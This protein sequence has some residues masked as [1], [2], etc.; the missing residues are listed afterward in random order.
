MTDIN[1]AK[2]DWKYKQVKGINLV[3]YRDM[4][5]VPKNIGECVLKWYHFYLQHPSSDRIYQT[6]TTLCRWPSLFDQARKLST[7]CTD[8][9]KLKNRSAKYALLPAKDAEVL[10]LWHK[11]CVDIFV[12]YTILFKLIQSDNKY[13]WRNSNYYAW[14]LST[15][16]QGGLKL[17]KSRS[18]INLHLEYLKYSIKYGCQNILGC[19]K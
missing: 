9:H 2:A 14:L 8:F 15:R 13:S 4:I 10:M 17:K 5:Y 1:K 18:L 6:I 3:H 12:T 16:K 7:I 11:L 19:A